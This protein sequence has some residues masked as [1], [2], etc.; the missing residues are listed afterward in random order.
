MRS[1]GLSDR[2]CP[3]V[4]LSVRPTKIAISRYVGI[5]ESDKY[6]QC[7]G[8]GK[9][10]QNSPLFGSSRKRL[11]TS[12]TNRVFLGDHAYQPHLLTIKR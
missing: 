1:K 6:I 10:P 12:A 11:V 7:V 5:N 4:C 8:N 3:S 2:L 9:K